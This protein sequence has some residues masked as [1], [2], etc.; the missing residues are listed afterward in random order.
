MQEV[1]LYSIMYYVLYAEL[2]GIFT[3]Q[4]IVILLSLAAASSCYYIHRFMARS[5]IQNYS[6][7]T[8]TYLTGSD[9]ESS[10]KFYHFCNH[11]LFN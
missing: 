5:V 2:R 6:T 9:F 10:I 4:G 8:N 1:L 7:N 3:L 11:H